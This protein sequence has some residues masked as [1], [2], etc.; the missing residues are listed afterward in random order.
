MVTTIIVTCSMIRDTKQNPLQVFASFI[1]I[2]QK[3]LAL[4]PNDS[5]IKSFV[6]ELKPIW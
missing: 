2:S 3:T 5:S 1:A 6:K 4:N